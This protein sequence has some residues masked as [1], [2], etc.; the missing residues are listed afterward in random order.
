LW[1]YWSSAAFLHGWCLDAPGL[2]AN[3]ATLLVLPRPNA[4]DRRG[5]SGDRR[6]NGWVSGWPGFGRDAKWR[7]SNKVSRLEVR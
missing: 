3:E 4:V 5:H 2:L 6:W 7:T 1:D